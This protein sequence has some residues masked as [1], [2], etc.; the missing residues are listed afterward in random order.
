MKVVSLRVE[1]GTI[2]TGGLSSLARCALESRHCTNGC[3]DD[4]RINYSRECLKNVP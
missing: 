4:M 1:L 3:G 2:F